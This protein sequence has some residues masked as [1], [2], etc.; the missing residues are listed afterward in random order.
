M[1]RKFIREARDLW[2]EI[3]AERY[4]PDADRLVAIESALGELATKKD[5]DT[6][7]ARLESIAREHV[8]GGRADLNLAPD[9]ATRS[10]SGESLQIYLRWMYAGVT[11]CGR[12]ACDKIAADLVAVGYTDIGSLHE[13]LAETREGFAGAAQEQRDQGINVDAHTDAMPLQLFLT[14]W[15]ESYCRAHYRETYRKNQSERAPWPWRRP[16][17][18]DRDGR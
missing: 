2:Y 9:L 15:D 18:R 4:G 16:A 1:K 7:V 10:I 8:P 12:T 11:H 14:L 3:C 5:V 17:P 13:I 6:L